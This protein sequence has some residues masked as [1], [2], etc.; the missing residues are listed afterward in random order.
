MGLF[1]ELGKGLNLL[2]GV[3]QSSNQQHNHSKNLQH[4]AQEFN[5]QAHQN[6]VADLQAAGL[7]P[8]LSAGSGG[9]DP[10]GMGNASTGS[11]AADPI[12]M[13]SA[14]VGMINSTKKNNAD[15]DKTEAETKNINTD[16]DVK[17]QTI[18]WT[19]ALNTALIK[20][21]NATSGK[22]MAEAEKKFAEKAAIQFDNKMREMNVKLRTQ[23]WDKEV[24]IYKETMRKE[25]RDAGVANSTAGIIVEQIG[26]TIHAMSPLSDFTPRAGN[27]YNYS[28]VNVTY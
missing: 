4:D 10:A 2:T 27:S 3:T 6:E 17:K 18:E 21:Q 20:L 16:T 24:N 9:T 15:I 19:P 1:H 11:A 26:K 25:L 5:K 8:V 22:E 12:S 13:I 23:E 14:I 28:P 7:N